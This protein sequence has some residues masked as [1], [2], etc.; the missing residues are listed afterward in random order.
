MTPKESTPKIINENEVKL[1]STQVIVGA[2]YLGGPFAAGYMISENYKA[3][4]KIK[5]GK[6]SLVLG[7]IATILVM[8]VVFSIPEKIINK[9]PNLL[10]PL[11]YSAIVWGIIELKLGKE[12]KNHQQ[13][14]NPFYSNWRGFGVGLVSA[15][16]TIVGVFGSL[17]IV[18]LN[19]E[20]YSQYDTEIQTFTK[21]ENAS[22]V[23]YEHL[24]TY[25]DVALIFEI[26]NT[27]IPLWKENIK[28]IEKLNTLEGLPI[29][30][31]KQNEI[32]LEYSKLRLKIFEL[33][34]KT[35][36]EETNIYD[37]ELEKLHRQV[38]DLINKLEQ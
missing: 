37:S 11:I 26:E 14:N 21:N 28:I 9:I 31:T 36:E 5:E 29:E 6:I 20:S 25:S 1:Y 35:A 16:I 17:Y 12:I 23:F 32:L 2:T 27:C 3:L 34:K 33:F 10:F 13:E 15:I 7:I 8:I 38:D 19:N 22:L 18:D 30:L 24:E 4:G